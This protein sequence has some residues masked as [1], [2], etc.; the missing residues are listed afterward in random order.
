VLAGLVGLV[1]TTGS[2]SSVPSPS[3]EPSFSSFPGPPRDPSGICR[4]PDVCPATT[5]DLGAAELERIRPDVESTVGRTFNSIGIGA[6]GIAIDLFPGHERLA[7]DLEGRFGDAVMIH[8]GTTRYC[9][10]PGRS[11]RCADAQGATTL[12]DGLHLAL[13]LDPDTLHGTEAAG[14]GTL[15]IRYDGP[16]TFRLE[17]GRPIVAHLVKPG[18]RTVVGTF[19]GMIAG[20]GLGLALTA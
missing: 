7:A 1:A 20:T 11:A 18:T 15:Q 9:G 3:F 5:R 17:T 19:T 13:T 6:H 4:P 8:L 14:R 2:S 10:G 12:P 16:G